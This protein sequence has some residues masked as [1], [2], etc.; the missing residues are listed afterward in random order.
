MIPGRPGTA[1]AHAAE[2]ATG[3]WSDAPTPGSSAAPPGGCPVI[4]RAVFARHAESLIVGAFGLH[5]FYLGKAGVGVL[6]L[7]FFWAYIAGLVAWFEGIS[8]LL[9]N[10]EE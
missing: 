8:S 9:A 4:T 10:D 6:S 5:K 3:T 2:P 7:V 1:A